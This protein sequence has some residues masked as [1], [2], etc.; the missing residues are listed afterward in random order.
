MSVAE[1]IHETGRRV[2][3]L[4]GG[5]SSERDVSLVSGAAVAEA[6]ESL[7]VPFELYE[8][9]ENRLP[10][11]LA[12]S[13]HLVLPVIHGTYGEDGRLSAEL[14][15]AGFV[16]AGCDQQSSVLCF[17]KFA[18]K[19]IAAR[20]GLPVAGDRLLAAGELADHNE[21][22]T[23]LGSPVILKPR[24]DGSSVGLH[25]VDGPEQL[26]SV[27]EDLLKTDYLAESYMEGIDLTVGILGGK[28]L[29]VVGVHPEGGLY[30]YKHKYTAGMSRYD[31]PAQIDAGVASQLKLWS[32]RIFAGCKCRDLA[33][34]DYRMSSTGEVI[35]L[36]INTIPGMTPTSL[37]PKSA[38][39]EDISFKDLVLRWIGFSL[40]RITQS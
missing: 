38:L 19:A 36:E 17:D 15:Q 1:R 16:Y 31:V 32:E 13:K 9:V 34:V 20:L 6:L 33:R 8:L 5:N 25:L 21:L 7:D 3:V 26:E 12:P 14:D 2:A 27:R 23:Q 18:T 11:E 35:F 40:N 30:D 28:A 39:C 22:T 10:E 24:H 4:C 37:L 29:G